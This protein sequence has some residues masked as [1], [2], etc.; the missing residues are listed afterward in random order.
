MLSGRVNPSPH[1]KA[2]PH[3]SFGSYLIHRGW[4]FGKRGRKD[5]P[6]L[7]PLASA[8]PPRRAAP[9]GPSS[10]PG[11]APTATQARAATAGNLHGNFAAWHAKRYRPARYLQLHP[12]RLYFPTKRCY[13]LLIAFTGLLRL[14]CLH[15]L[16]RLVNVIPATKSA[17]LMVMRQLGAM[18]RYTTSQ[19]CTTLHH[20]T[21]CDSNSWITTN[22]AR[23]A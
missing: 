9:M 2:A 14:I 3:R 17:R 18:Q 1:P 22:S 7:N 16:L 23:E 19:Q 12:A 8:I 13:L 11:A 15:V 4:L 5:K 6:C 21:W 20:T 10:S